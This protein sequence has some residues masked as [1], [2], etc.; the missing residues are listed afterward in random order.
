MCHEDGSFYVGAT[1]RDRC[2]DRVREHES[3]GFSGTF[4]YTD[5]QNMRLAEDKLL[6]KSPYG[7]LY[8]DQKKSNVQ[9]KPGYIYLINGWRMAS[10]KRGL[11]VSSKI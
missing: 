4:C 1:E 10:K 5:T 9:E 3:K 8:N 6:D 2:D 7:Y 11:K